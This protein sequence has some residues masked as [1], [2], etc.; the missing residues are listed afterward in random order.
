MKNT[1][2]I[3][4]HD[5]QLFAD[6]GADG[7]AEAG[8]GAG[9]TGV[10][11]SAA[12]VQSGV[13]GNQQTG[14][15]AEDG[16]P[17][18][19]VQNKTEQPTAADPNAEFEAL[20]KGKYKDQY[21]AK[22]SDT[23][24]KRLRAQSEVAEKYKTLMPAMELLARRYGVQDVSD[25]KAIVQ[26]ILSD[27]ALIEDAA[28]EAGMET[29]AFRRL[30]RAESEVAENRRQQNEQRRLEGQRQQYETWVKQAEAAKVKYPNLDLETEA[31]NEKFME[32]LNSNIDVANAYLIVHQDELMYGAMQ[33]A[34]KMATQQVAKSVAAGAARPNENGTGQGAAT[35]KQD[36]RKMTKAQRQDYI[37]RAGR[38]ETITF[39]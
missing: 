5:L 17:V 25:S 7:G 10:N 31:Q 4:M 24:Q 38:G 30:V 28:M 6:G 9:G 27:D 19:E 13:K 15:P 2:I 20:I 8:N 18:A 32:L 35:V 14:T 22:V 34:T 12:G 23:V 16:A 26:A 39:R 3:S 29:S 37:R 11:A 36:P 21:N 1:E 33:T